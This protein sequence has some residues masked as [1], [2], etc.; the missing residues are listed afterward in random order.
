MEKS[1][2][3]RMIGLAAA[4][5]IVSVFAVI[6]AAAYDVDISQYADNALLQAALEQAFIDYPNESI[7]VTGTD[8]STRNISVDLTTRTITW[9]A[10]TPNTNLSYSFTFSQ[11][12]IRRNVRFSGATLQSLT[13]GDYVWM[14]GT[15][16]LTINCTSGNAVT[17]GSQC[18]FIID[19]NTVITAAAGNAIYAGANTGTGIDFAATPNTFTASGMLIDGTGTTVF[20][21][22]DTVVDES[23]INSSTIQ[24]DPPSDTTPPDDS[25]TTNPDNDMTDDS[26]PSSSNETPQVN[27]TREVTNNSMTVMS[28]GFAAPAGYTPPTI[29]IKD[30]TQFEQDGKTYSGTVD[31]ANVNNDK[32]Q[33][34]PKEVFID[35]ERFLVGDTVYI[36]GTEEK[37]VEA[38]ADT[39]FT[40]VFTAVENSDAP[41]KFSATGLPEGL[42]ISE[43]GVITTKTLPAPVGTFTIKV[44]ADNGLDTHTYEMTIEIKEGG[45]SDEELLKALTANDNP[46]LTPQV[47]ALPGEEST[48][49]ENGENAEN[50]ES[51]ESE[52]GR[53]IPTLWQNGD[54]KL[55]YTPETNDF[56]ALF[57]DG[58]LLTPEVDYLIEEGSTVIILTEQ[59][60]TP[61]G[62]GDHVVTT[63]FNQNTDVGLD[64]VIND[65]GSSSFVFRFG[66]G[67]TDGK[68]INIGGDGVMGSVTFDDTNIKEAPITTITANSEEITV[69]AANLSNATGIEIVAAFETRQQ[70]GFGGKTAT[71]AVSAKSLDLDLENGTVIYVAV[72]D[73][74]SGKTYQN[75]GDVKDEMLVFKTRHSGVFMIALEKF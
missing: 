9:A 26:E 71:F 37:K 13:L 28:D 16:E 20:L 51:E 40:Y 15:S 14:S 55:H 54:L 19:S 38:I 74:V 25:D 29:E 61:L 58:K 47:L 46:D 69:R 11:D 52:S 36:V 3:K 67:E 75:K 35:G 64:T 72:Y 17:L 65:I 66:D 8:T 31:I 73:P 5:C 22:Y 21:S 68:R 7:V 59:T 50:T 4:V 27:E 63:M 49:G 43:D 39:G 45:L 24:R 30:N 32:P 60:M 44:T 33:E 53:E 34:I 1:I 42:E 2:L 48:E 70:G 23:L 56:F 10:Y 57:L 18:Y 41:V 6:N 12:A 62:G